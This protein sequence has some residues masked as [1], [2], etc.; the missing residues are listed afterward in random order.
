MAPVWGD[1]P[2]AIPKPSLSL[3]SLCQGLRPDLLQQ[4]GGTETAARRHQPGAGG[5]EPDHRR[6]IQASPAHSLQTL[7]AVALAQPLAPPIT[8]EWHMAVGRWRHPQQPHQRHLGPGGWPQINPAHHFCDAEPQLVHG[9]GEVIGKKAIGPTQH[10]IPHLGG[11]VKTARGGM[12][13]LPAD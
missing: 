13:L 8:E 5:Q 9:C 4:L 12:T 6:C 2:P 1:L 10:H 11:G 3:Q 7:S